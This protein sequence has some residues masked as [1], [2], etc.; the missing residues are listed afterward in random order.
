MSMNTDR[1]LFDITI[2]VF[3]YITGVALYIYTYILL[4]L[5]LLLLLLY[6]PHTSMHAWTHQCVT[7]DLS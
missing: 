4:L 3:S 1:V 5:L 7:C 2:S 6:I